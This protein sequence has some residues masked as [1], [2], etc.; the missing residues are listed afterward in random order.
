VGDLP[1]S[2]RWERGAKGGGK[3]KKSG[4]DYHRASRFARRHSPDYEGR[5]PKE[6][7][8]ASKKRTRE[9][10]KTEGRKATVQKKVKKCKETKEERGRYNVTACKTGPKEKVVGDSTKKKRG[11]HSQ[12]NQKNPLD[13]SPK[14]LT[15]KSWTTF[16]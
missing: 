8:L 6:D 7:E 10:E 13:E 1:E 4:G 3:H 2:K 12:G 5:V 14:E 16:L 11:V 9:R 15:H